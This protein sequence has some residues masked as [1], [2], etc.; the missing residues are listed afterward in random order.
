MRVFDVFGDKVGTIDAY[1]T[2]HDYLKVSRSRF[3]PLDMF[4][5][6]ALVD[7]V[8]LVACDVHLAVTRD[9]LSRV[10]VVMPED[11]SAPSTVVAP[12]N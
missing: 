9:H 4:V 7:G 11:G 3:L 8:D 1:N 10:C 5:P 12:E 2:A 6:L